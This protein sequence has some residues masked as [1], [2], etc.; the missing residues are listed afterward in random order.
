M[1]TIVTRSGKGSPLTNNEMDDNLNNINNGKTENSSAAIS[2]GYIDNVSLGANTSIISINVSGNATFTSTSAIK[3]PVGTEAQRPAG[4]AGQLR[5]NSN[6]DQFEGYNG[7]LWSGISGV[8]FLFKTANYTAKNNDYIMTDTSAGGFTITLPATPAAGN[9]ITIYDNASWAVNNL[10]VARN[11]STIESIADDF[12]LDISS[13]KVE[14][15]Y[16]GSTW[17]VYSSVGQNGPGEPAITI[18]DVAA[19]AIALG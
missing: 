4:V 3:I 5:F 12:A 7:T 17:Q 10:I 11:G 1:V 14:F 8:S 16:N 2:G 15:I 6:T 19:L 9:I 13:I 18:S